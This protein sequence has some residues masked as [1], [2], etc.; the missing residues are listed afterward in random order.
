MENIKVID[1]FYKCDENTD[2]GQDVQRLYHTYELL[3]T[4][5]HSIRAYYLIIRKYSFAVS[6][7]INYYQFVILSTLTR[8]VNDLATTQIITQQNLHNN[9]C[10]D[11]I[12]VSV[13]SF[14]IERIIVLS[15]ES[16]KNN[17]ITS[18]YNYGWTCGPNSGCGRTWTKTTTFQGHFVFI[19]GWVWHF[20]IIGLYLKSRLELSISD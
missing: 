3:I 18:V 2:D 4:V 6:K 7:S 9:H 16:Q 13:K 5:P 12:F 20:I 14:S 1:S 8:F 11:A 19:T 15:A 17:E 10:T